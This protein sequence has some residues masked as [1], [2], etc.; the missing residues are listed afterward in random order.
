MKIFQGIK[1]DW[2]SPDGFVNYD[3]FPSNEE[4]DELQR[5]EDEAME[6]E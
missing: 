6:E 3:Y 5:E 4:L 1:F 2:Q